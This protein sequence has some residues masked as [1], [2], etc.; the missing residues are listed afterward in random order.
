MGPTIH[1]KMS[2][3]FESESWKSRAAGSLAKRNQLLSLKRV[4]AGLPPGAQSTAILDTSAYSQGGHST[5]PKIYNEDAALDTASILSPA[6]G[7]PPSLPARVEPETF[8]ESHAS[9]FGYREVS[10]SPAPL[11]ALPPPRVKPS[12]DQGSGAKLEQRGRR[13]SL[14]CASPCPHASKNCNN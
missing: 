3:Q 9:R 10:S 4:G 13:P 14:A 8:N 2:Q 5:S 7:R 6:L 11:K 1:T 12:R